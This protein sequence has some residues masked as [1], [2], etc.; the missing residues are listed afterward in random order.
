[1]ARVT[2]IGGVFFK[3]RDPE[4][5]AAWYRDHLGVPFDEKMGCA[6]LRWG[7]DPDAAGAS[8]VWAVSPQDSE[9]YD[10][11]QANFMINY[12]VDD[13]AG[14]LEKLQAAGTPIHQGPEEHFHGIFAWV[15]DPEGNKVELW[16]PT[17]DPD[18]PG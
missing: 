13:M 1:M 4:A 11:G 17:P 12:R 8:T 6:I 9:K 3:A 18:S 5:Q 15:L 2:G 7:Q 14:I 16:Q 10:P